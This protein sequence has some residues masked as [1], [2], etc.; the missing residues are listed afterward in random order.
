MKNV[1][2]DRWSQDKIFIIGDTAHQF[3]PSGGYGL[4]QGVSDAFSL[5]WR[6]FY[7]LKNTENLELRESFEKE[8]NIHTNV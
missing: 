7:M 1:V 3:P 5:A 6:L 8:R 2:V 4:N